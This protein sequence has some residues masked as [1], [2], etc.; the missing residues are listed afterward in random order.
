MN[1]YITVTIIIVLIAGFFFVKKYI[2]TDVQDYDAVNAIKNGA[3]IIDVR[4]KD[5]FDR[6][7]VPTAANIH[8]SHIAQYIKELAPNQDQPILLYCQ[9]GPRA[10]IAQKTLTNMGYTQVKSLGSLA[11]AQKVYRAAQK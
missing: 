7:A 9:M 1:Q 3:L 11:K 2:M 6:G 8:Y 4:T 10:R 5:E